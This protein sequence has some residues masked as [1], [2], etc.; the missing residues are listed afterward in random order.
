VPR[1]ALEPGRDR[2]CVERAAPSREAAAA[3]ADQRL[4]EGRG[5]A[6]DDGAEDHDLVLHGR[7][8]RQR[9][10]AVEEPARPR[11]PGAHDPGRSLDPVAGAPP[12][13]EIAGSQDTVLLAI[14][15]DVDQRRRE[16]VEP[17]VASFPGLDGRAHAVRQR[18]VVPG[19]DDDELAARCRDQ[20]RKVGADA[21]VC[22][23]ADDRERVRPV[24]APGGLLQRCERAVR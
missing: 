12:A 5:A 13:R 10:E 7:A 2:P 18:D 23:L 1:V 20:R 8:R 11:L 16:E 17:A 3:V 22:G 14:G 15:V 24:V 19:G 21:E 9:A 6:R 4:G